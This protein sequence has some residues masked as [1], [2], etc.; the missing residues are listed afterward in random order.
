[1]AQRR[2]YAHELLMWLGL[3]HVNPMVQKLQLVGVVSTVFIIVLLI[4]V[5]FPHRYIVS[6]LIW[7]PTV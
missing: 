2:R 4:P 3:E 6:H 5:H 7:S 1:M